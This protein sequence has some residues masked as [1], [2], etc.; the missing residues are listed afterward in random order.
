MDW[1]SGSR[2]AGFGKHRKLVYFTYST[3]T[4]VIGL[5][6][7]YLYLGHYQHL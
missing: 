2:I 5:V 7:Q 4:L 3:L 6:T 1:G